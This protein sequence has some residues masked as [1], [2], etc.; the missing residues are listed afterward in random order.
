MS[1]QSGRGV[2]SSGSCG[3]PLALANAA[4]TINLNS[5]PSIKT[6]LGHPKDGEFAIKWVISCSFTGGSSRV[7]VQFTSGTFPLPSMNSMVVILTVQLFGFQ[8]SGLYADVPSVFGQFDP[9]SGL[10]ANRSSA[11]IALPSQSS[12]GVRPTSVQ[13]VMPL[14]KR[15]FSYGGREFA[16]LRAHHSRPCTLTIAST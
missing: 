7:C 10:F 6:V 5:V 14:K 8:A 12:S 11:E 15:H 1:A 4:G 2:N 13:D 9:V 16:A 3:D